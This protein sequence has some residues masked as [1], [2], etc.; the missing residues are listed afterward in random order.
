MWHKQYNLQY[1]LKCYSYYMD[2]ITLEHKS[3]QP[4]EKKWAESPSTLWK[5]PCHNLGCYAKTDPCRACA[6]SLI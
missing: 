4:G 1:E 3:D 5:D 6:V 2:C